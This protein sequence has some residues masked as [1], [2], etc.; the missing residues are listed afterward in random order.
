MTNQTNHTE[1]LLLMKLRQYWTQLTKFCLL[2]KL[3]F[4]KRHPKNG[5][6]LMHHV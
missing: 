5:F 3:F 1:A 4:Q 6:N 2:T